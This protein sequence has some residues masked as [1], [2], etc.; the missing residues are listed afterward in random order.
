MTTTLYETP[1]HAIVCTAHKGMRARKLSA[2]RADAW[3]AYVWRET[4]QN[5]PCETCRAKAERAVVG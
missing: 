4:G 2:A 3:T 5:I 1:Y